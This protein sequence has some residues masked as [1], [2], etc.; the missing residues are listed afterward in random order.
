MH[1]H[2]MRALAEARLVSQRDEAD[3]QRLATSSWIERGALGTTRP[4]RNRRMHFLALL[5]RTI[6]G[7]ETSR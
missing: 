1:D 6:P 7:L 5:S 4:P 2:H 3:R